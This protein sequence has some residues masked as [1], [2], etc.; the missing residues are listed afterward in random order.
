MVLTVSFF[1]S[2]TE[3]R[4]NERDYIPFYHNN[5]GERKLHLYTNLF[6]SVGLIGVFNWFLLI[7][8]LCLVRFNFISIIRFPNKSPKI[9]KE[10]M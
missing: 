3:L 10:K 7:I 9:I 6:I 4:K 1:L 5:Y 2:L 8:L